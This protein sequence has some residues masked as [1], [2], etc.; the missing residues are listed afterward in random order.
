MPRA[1]IITESL[2]VIRYGTVGRSGFGGVVVQ[3]VA[4]QGY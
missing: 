4:R 3:L 2:C 1:F